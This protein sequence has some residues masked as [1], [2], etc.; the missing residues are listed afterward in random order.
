MRTL[1][2][3]SPSGEHGVHS[4]AERL[5]VLLRRFGDRGGW[6]KEKEETYCSLDGCVGWWRMVGWGE[7][8]G[9][10]CWL[11]GCMHAPEQERGIWRL[12]VPHCA[13]AAGQARLGRCEMQKL[14][15]SSRVGACG[16]QTLGARP[17]FF[18]ED[19]GWSSKPRGSTAW[20]CEPASGE[21]YFSA[22]LRVTG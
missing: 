9:E 8:G 3:S 20:T 1:V 14:A 10:V 5:A 4:R 6:L 11:A 18:F 22:L 17:S 12:P 7:Q 16:R 2:S 15:E 13:H 21:L 19:P